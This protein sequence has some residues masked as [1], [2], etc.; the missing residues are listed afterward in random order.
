MGS[1]IDR[2]AQQDSPQFNSFGAPPAEQPNL[3]SNLPVPWDPSAAPLLLPAAVLLVAFVSARWLAIDGGAPPRGLGCGIAAVL[4]GIAFAVT[5]RRRR[6]WCTPNAWLWIPFLLGFEVGRTADCGHAPCDLGTQP[7]VVTGRVDAA[8]RVTRSALERRDPG[9]PAERVRTRLDDVQLGTSKV[10]GSLAVILP[11]DPDIGRGDRVEL[12]FWSDNERRLEPVKLREHVRVIA[13]CYQPLA[14]LDRLRRQ[15]RRSW[16]ARFGATS[17]GWLAALLLGEMDLLSESTNAS[18]RAT[19]QSH[20]LVISGMHV[21]I[22]F[23]MV[24]WVL[25]RL[26]FGGVRSLTLAGALL[27][28]FYSG[29]AGGDAPVLRA[30]LLGMLGALATAM[31]RSSTAANALA[32]TFIVL[33]CASGAEASR[34]SFVLTFSAV[35]G[36]VFLGP[37]RDRLVSFIQHRWRRRWTRLRRGL[38]VSVAAWLGASTALVWWTPDVVLWGP[39]FTLLLMPLFT[40][41]LAT[42]LVA[43]LPSALALDRPLNFVFTLEWRLFDAMAECFDRWPG[44]PLPLPPIPPLALSLAFASLGVWFF[45]R[46]LRWAPLALLGAS[47]FVALWPPPV[48]R[49]LIVD[50]GRGAGCAIAGRSATVV[51]D[52]GSLDRPG[53]GAKELR[54]E[55]RRCGRAVIDLLVLS[56][57]HADHVLATPEL[58]DLLAVRRVLVGPRFDSSALGAGLLRYLEHAQ[59]PVQVAS[60]GA[61][62]RVGGFIVA[63]L[64]PPKDYPAVIPMSL[65]DDSLVVRIRGEGLDL[66]SMGDLQSS[67]LALLPCP[68]DVDMLVLP[69]HGRYQLALSDWLAPVAPRVVL[70]SSAGR[71]A[72][73]TEQLMRELPTVFHHTARDGTI[74]IAPL[75]PDNSAVAPSQWHIVPSTRK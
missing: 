20:L 72:R 56:H 4:A 23:G 44:T 45:R 69:H 27:I 67:G 62:L 53:A 75:A 57:A 11:G 6:S 43:L 28:A 42:G 63:V 71:G 9:D 7:V 58:V 37:S 3:R 8:P 34:A 54:A 47:C 66:I 55:L 60:A 13:R 35:A 46:E 36:I 64:H 68:E 14:V 12:E 40:L 29:L 51:L 5:H 52:A 41:L 49:A 70:A 22:L 32:L 26:P 1:S 33:C 18:F 61:R 48:P 2:S 15:L 25:E 39:L 16:K 65:N 59:V 30:T 50:L 74:V 10:A 21:V 19:G 38:H 73:R 17:A 31:G 24:R